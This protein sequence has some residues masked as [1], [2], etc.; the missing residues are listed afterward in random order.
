MAKKNKLTMAQGEA[1]TFRL[2]FF[3][4]GGSA[5]ELDDREDI[6]GAIVHLAVKLNRADTTPPLLALVSPTNITI[7]AQSGAT[8]GQADV[9]FVAAN[10]LTLAPN[11]YSWDA[12]RVL[13]ADKKRPIF[14]ELVIERTIAVI[15]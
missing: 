1:K 4:L 12:W 8:I 11:T 6:T 7:L 13:G 9:A 5:T 14:G 2:T 3:R 15:P 10:T